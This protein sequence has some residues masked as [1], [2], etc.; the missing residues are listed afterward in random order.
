MSND[1]SELESEIL[2][3][4]RKVRREIKSLFR[5]IQVCFILLFLAMIF[6]EIAPVLLIPGIIFIVISPVIFDLARY[7]RKQFYD[8]EVSQAQDEN[9]E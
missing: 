4:D 7:V 8:A 3:F 6:P 5:L 1:L 2:R 9:K